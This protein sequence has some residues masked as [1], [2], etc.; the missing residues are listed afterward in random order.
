MKVTSTSTE[1]V[2][3]SFATTEG[4]LKV[5]VYPDNYTTSQLTIAND[6]TTGTY[7]DDI[8]IADTAGLHM[9]AG[10][11]YNLAFIVDTSGSMSSTGIEA[12][13]AS[14][15]TTFQALLADAKATGVG[16]VNVLLVD[17]ATQVKSTVAVT[18]NDAGLKTLLNA[19]SGMSADGGTNY[20][21]AFKTT[22]NWFQSLKNAGVTGTN[23]TYFLTDGQPTYYQTGE[24]TNPALANSS[25]KLDTLLSN[26]SYKMGDT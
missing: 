22:A 21:D 4:T 24:Q 14:L 25:V 11:N 8:I 5:T 18:L 1:S 26:I 23:Q 6:S 10:T 20:E 13:K 12:T 3:G 16:T 19:L 17:F 7:G 9:T 2:G 15:A